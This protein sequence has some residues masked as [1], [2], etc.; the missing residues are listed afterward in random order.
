MLNKMD[1]FL[2]EVLAADDC[3]RDFTKVWEKF[4]RWL[5][6][7]QGI[8]WCNGDFTLNEMRD[9]NRSPKKKTD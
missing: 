1:G 7:M 9:H 2:D 5:G 3:A 4:N 8:L 6:F